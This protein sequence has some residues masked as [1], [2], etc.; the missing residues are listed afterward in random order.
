M[1]AI[2]SSETLVDFKMAHFSRQTRRKKFTLVWF[3]LVLIP[4]PH[5]PLGTL[6]ST[7]HA[8]CSD[9]SFAS[10]AVVKYSV[11]LLAI[12]IGAS[13]LFFYFTYP[14]FSVTFL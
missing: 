12:E 1:E 4:W 11:H 13:P 2:C 5:R 6:T 10:V 9:L 7:T 3:D 14:N 8:H